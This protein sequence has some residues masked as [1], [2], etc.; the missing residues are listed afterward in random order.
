M[1]AKECSVLDRRELFSLGPALTAGTTAL[2]IGAANAA[3]DAELSESEATDVASLCEV[4]F[5]GA[6]PIWP[7]SAKACDLSASTA[8]GINAERRQLAEEVGTPEF[9]AQHGAFDVASY[10]EYQ[11]KDCPESV[12]TGHDVKVLSVEVRGATDDGDLVVW[13]RVWE[14]WHSASVDPATGA[15]VK[16]RTVD[17]TPTHEVIVRKTEGGFRIVEVNE[18][19]VES[20]DADL[21]AYGPETAHTESA[22]RD[23]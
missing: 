11:R 10:M 3:R 19:V 18:D 2:C 17:Q 21:S 15:L 20:S 4:W 23:L 16:E 8:R 22:A 7:T 14:G 12:W 1:T 9:V 13:V 6:L 5:A